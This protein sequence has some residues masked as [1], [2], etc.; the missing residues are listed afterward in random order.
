MFYCCKIGFVCA[1]QLCATGNW[2][3]RGKGKSGVKGGA[4]RVPLPEHEST[5]TRV[6]QRGGRRPGEP[7]RQLPAS[8]YRKSIHASSN[9]TNAPYREATDAGPNC[10]LPNERQIAQAESRHAQAE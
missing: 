6:S 1:L 3:L 8:T 4:P 9:L 2:F 7:R 5:I 10:V